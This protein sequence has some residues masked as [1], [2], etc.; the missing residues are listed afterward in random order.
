MSNNKDICVGKKY[1][2]RDGNEKTKWITIGTVISKGDGKLFIKIDVIPT[3]WNG[4][5]S[6]FD[7][8]DRNKNRQEQ[9]W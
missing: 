1:T 2:D 5:A 6:I 7:K 4:F 3:E 8:V 9:K